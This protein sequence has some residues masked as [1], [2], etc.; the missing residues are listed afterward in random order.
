MNALEIVERAAGPAIATDEKGMILAWNRA[1]RQLL[2]YKDG[3]VVKGK[4]FNDLLEAR[5]VFGNRFD[6]SGV[7]F[8]E[9][10]TRGESVNSFEIFAHKK[11]GERLRVSVSVVVV[12]KPKPSQYNL[13]YLLRPVQRRRRADEAI[14]R[15]LSNPESARTV[16]DRANQGEKQPMADLTRRQADVLHLLAQGRN[17]DEIADVLCVSVHT[18]RSHVQNILDKLQVRNKAEAVSRAFRENLI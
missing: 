5:D 9:M 13:V 2:A 17:N 11:T 15:I 14:E 16:P 7:P 1:A 4:L 8:Y 6:N 3:A 10:I 18:V 12:L